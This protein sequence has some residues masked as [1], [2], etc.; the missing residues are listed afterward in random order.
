MTVMLNQT[1]TQKGVWMKLKRIFNDTAIHHKK[2]GNIKV[3]L[4]MVSANWRSY[5]VYKSWCIQITG[6]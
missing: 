2:T 3:S 5:R 1:K 6:W 4:D